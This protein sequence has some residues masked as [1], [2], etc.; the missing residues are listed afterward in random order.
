VAFLRST[1]R[2]M[3]WTAWRLRQHP[4]TVRRRNRNGLDVITAGLRRDAVAVF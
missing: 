4:A 3:E 2:D 1:E